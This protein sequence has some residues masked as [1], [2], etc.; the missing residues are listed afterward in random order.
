MRLPRWLKKRKGKNPFEGSLIIDNPDIKVVEAK[1][2]KK[3]VLLAIG[4]SK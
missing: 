4:T 2:D 3:P 1:Y